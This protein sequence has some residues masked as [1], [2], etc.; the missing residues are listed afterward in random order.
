MIDSAF[1]GLTA[2]TLQILAPNNDEM[3]TLRIILRNILC[4]LKDG[5]KLAPAINNV[6]AAF[7]DCPIE[8]ARCVIVGQDPYPG[9]DKN[10]ETVAD[11]KSYSTKIGIKIQPSAN[12]I[13]KC[14]IRGNLMRE[15]PKGGGDLHKW[16]RQ[17][18]LLLNSVL[19]TKVG[20]T[21]SHIKEWK[22][23]MAQL[24]K[25]ICAL[26]V[27]FILLGDHA[28]KTISAA[29]KGTTIQPTILAW[30]HPSPLNAA[31]QKADDPNNIIYCTCFAETNRILRERELT[32]INWDLNAANAEIAIVRNDEKIEVKTIIEKTE[33]AQEIVE[34]TNPTTVATKTE[35]NPIYVFT[36]G[37]AAANGKPNCRASWAYCIPAL[38]AE[39]RAIV[40]PI[41]IDGKVYAASN[42]RGELLGII[43][44]IEY[45]CGDGAE[46]IRDKDIIICGDSSYALNCL[47]NWG[48]KWY[49][50]PKKYDLDKKLNL[51]LIGPALNKVKELRLIARSLTFQ[52]V[53]AHQKEPMAAHDT[54]EWQM[55]NG[56]RMAD[57]LCETLLR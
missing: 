41:N 44:A 32:E 37:A 52:H 22:S 7:R 1:V 53:R 19:T 35:Q 43:R 54:I 21:K 38:N 42:N 40:E 29:I 2:A 15:M 16:A 4:G 33:I 26:P 57:R 28:Q 14:L 17:G 24:F 13:F 51:D 5:E 49:E 11:G 50:N 48:P 45:M 8:A 34:R 31:N 6:F 47:S 36:D 3:V 46:S 9:K 39:N 25:R 12:N 56:N 18:V 55:W 30:G 10:G 27:I 23:Y 20:E